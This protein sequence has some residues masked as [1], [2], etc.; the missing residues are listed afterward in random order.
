VLQE[1]DG[2][3]G[4]SSNVRPIGSEIFIGVDGWLAAIGPFVLPIA[5]ML[6]D[7]Q[8]ANEWHFG[9]IS[10]MFKALLSMMMMKMIDKK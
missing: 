5:D 10:L 7:D 2:G 4:V 3:G 6:V 8:F 9:M 1:G